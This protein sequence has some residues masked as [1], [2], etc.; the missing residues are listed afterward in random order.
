VVICAIPPTLT[1]IFSYEKWNYKIRRLAEVSG[2][3]FVDPYAAIRT[4]NN[5][6]K[7]PSKYW[8]NDGTHP[9]GNGGRLA[10]Q[11]ITPAIHEAAGR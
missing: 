8:T 1:Y 6:W 7:S 10:A 9:N 4:D 5:G 2:W 11:V 3:T